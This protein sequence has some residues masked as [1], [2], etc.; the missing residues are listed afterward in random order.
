MKIQH[1][2]ENAKTIEQLLS[3]MEE[4]I[5]EAERYNIYLT[6]PKRGDVRKEKLTAHAL[7]MKPY[8]QDLYYRLVRPKAETLDDWEL[9]YENYFPYEGFVSDEIQVDP[10]HSYREKTSFA[11]SKKPFEFLSLKQKGKTWMSVTPHEINTMTQQVQEAHGKVITF[12]LGL[13]YY[14][15]ACAEKESVSSVT[16]IE[17]DPKIIKIFKE[18]LLPFFPHKGKIRVIQADAFAY[19][20]K[21]MK[22]EGFDYAFVDLWHLP[23]DGLPMYLKMRPCEKANPKTEFS[24]W[25]EPSLLSLLRRATTILLKEEYEGSTD[26]DYDYAATESDLIVNGLHKALKRASLETPNDI[27]NL[28]SDS[29]LKEISKSLQI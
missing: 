28:L 14:A 15:F 12:G 3:T 13:G 25:V 6:N 29:S 11:Y 1:S 9:G 8:C 10:A 2:P 16:V 5:A 22:K 18:R 7:V 4:N 24:Y 26:E 19:A 27:L 23:E 21:D 17:I 20:R